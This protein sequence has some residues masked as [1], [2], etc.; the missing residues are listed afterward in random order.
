MRSSLSSHLLLLTVLSS[1]QP[2]LAQADW[3]VLTPATVPTGRTGH[4]MAYDAA[5]DRIVMFGGNIGGVGFVNDTWL[6]DG[7][8]WTQVFPATSPPARAGHPMA[9]D[10]ARQRTV[11]Y[12]GIPVG[13]GALSDTWEWDGQNWTQVFT[14]TSPPPKRSQPM[15]YHPIRQTVLMWGGYDGGVDVADT[16]EFNGIDWSQIVTANAPQ[17]RRATDMAFDPNTGGV[18]LF[19]GY[20]RGADT[21]SFDGLDWI[22]L[23][24][25][26][27]PGARYD[28]TMVTDLTRSRIVMFG[29]NG[30]GD[31]WEWD[32]ADWLQRQPATSPSPRFDD[33]LVWDLLRE[34]VVMFGGVATTPADMWAYRT[35]A[36][37][38]FASFGTGC[39]GTNGSAPA[40]GS[41]DRPWI[42]ESYDIEVVGLPPSAPAFMF[43]GFSNTTWGGVSL[44]F[45]LTVI[46]MPGCRLLVDPRA[47]YP[48]TNVSGHALSSLPV[49]V[50]TRLLGRAVYNQ[51][52]V[53]DAGANALNTTVSNGGAG[54]FGAK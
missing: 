1:A 12:G 30:I 38:S 4:G 7:T 8:T 28:H 14:T 5:N 21:W 35:T 31:T 48:L 15:I 29:G 26:T 45:D 52:V 50:D 46:G 41:S 9:Y 32:G 3:T 13:G 25:A 33:Y 18:L 40:L 37:A 42:G 53:F 44:P 10:M 16:W 43:I 11:V 36:P 27:V 23:T 47:D 51:A 39:R 2:L 24:P 49:P 22:Q 19:S 54:T 20:Q 6:Y 17:G 34:R